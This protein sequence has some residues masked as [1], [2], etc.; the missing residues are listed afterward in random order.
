MKKVM[1][2][3]AVMLLVAS[4][5]AAAPASKVL[6]LPVTGQFTDAAGGLGKFTGSV[7]IIDFAPSG[8]QVVARGYVV[9]TLTDSTGRGLGTVVKP[10][11]I[12][13]DLSDVTGSGAANARVRGLAIRT[14]ATCD[15]L[16]LVLGPLHLDLLGLVVDLNQVVL[17]ITG[18]TGAGNLLGNLLCSLLG[19]LDGAGALVDISQLLNRILD[20]LSGILG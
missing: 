4:V 5:A 20:V 3:T 13:V 1:L 6:T 8:D 9:G 18:E 2:A 11:A 15:I 16:G 17:D 14:D 12:P 10:V 19:L 7:K